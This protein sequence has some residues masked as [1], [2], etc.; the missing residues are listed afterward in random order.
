MAE[1]LVFIV[2]QKIGAALGREALNVV[3]T[4]LQKQPP[5]L[6]DVENNMRQLKIE[7]NVM[8]AFLTQQQI[9]FSQDRA[10]DAWLDEVKNVA[11][12][13]EDVID[14]YVY[15]AGQTA[16]E[17]S[18]LKKLFH[19]SKTTSDWHII[20]T[21]LSQIKSRLQNLTNMKARYGISA[22]DSEDGST[23]SHESLKELTSD[24]A[25]FDTEDDMVG[26]KE[27]YEKV[28]K[29]LI[30][31][32]E[33]R[34]VISI[35]G[36]GGL[37]KTTLARAIYKKNEIRKNFDCFSWIT[38]SQN[39]KVEDLFRRILKQLLDMNENIPDQT[40]IMYRVSLVERLRNYLQDKKYLIFLD[41]M[42]S[43]DA[44][45]LLD[46]AFV[47]NKK[48]SR[49]VITTR[50]EDVASI[51]NNG[52]SFKPKYLPRGDA[53]DLFCRKAFHRLDQNGCPQVVMHWAE[54]IVSKCEGLPLAI[55]AIGSLLSYKQIDEAEWKLFY[56]QLNWQLTKNQKLN[57]VTSIL[58]L[59][60]DYLPANLKNCF[61]YC[62]M[63][64][65]DHEIRRKQIIRLWIAEG[66]I[67]ERGDITLEEVA[68]DYL[69]ELVQRSLLQVAWTKEY[70]RPK[71]F[72]MHDLVRDITVT[73]CKTEKFSLL[74]D[75]T[76]VTKLSDEARRVS[77][78]KGGKAMESGQG[79]RKIRSFIL[80]DEEVQFSW[81]QKATSN[82]RL[83]RVLSLRY[84][85]IVKLPDAV[86][87]LFNLHYL[88]LRHSEVQE[89][90]QSIGKLRK[91]Q[92][93][94]LRETFVEQLPE[95]IKFLTKL[96]FLS[97]DIDCDPSNL[98]RHFPRFQ[99]TR[100]CSEFYLL[101]DL[102]VLGDIKAS[103]HVVT[104]LNRLTQLRCLGIRDVKQDHMEK[105]CVSIKSMPNLI[106]LGIVSCG[107]DEILDLQHLD[108][109]PDLEW[110]HLRGKLH[111][112]GA[113]SKLQN[114]SKLRYLSIGWSRLQV[115]PLPAISHLSN[116]AELY[117]QEAYD[118]LLMTFQAG[119]FPNLRELGL[120]DMDQ[121]RSID[122][123]A[124]TMS[125]LSILV[126]CGLQNM[127]S[128]PV[129]FKYL[130]S[131]QILR[132]WDMPK[133]FMERTHAEDHVYVKH[134]HQIRYH[135]LRVKRWK[136]TSKISHLH[137]IL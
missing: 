89:I 81:I 57:Y 104:N 41:D 113:T 32:E 11:H 120:A 16:K 4:Q 6:V 1:A 62:S 102:H 36:M 59:S 37:G 35:C 31:G 103:K 87:Y 39:Y 118:G 65:E 80:F 9:H 122:I 123:E 111:G 30:H 58:N 126:L 70:E 133:E 12:E 110:L 137:S 5:T 127:I 105:L 78:V 92:T 20:A 95:E 94:D 77:L 124:G 88:D 72:R 15:L 115:D 54:K 49:I 106:R 116:L 48:G 73:K 107:E 25:Y 86:T 29:L 66:F 129:G 76:C 45:I 82:F 63:F 18:K 130:T 53:W 2:L 23:S 131:L 8:K 21:Q 99:A 128:V 69:K 85:K 136:F 75:N 100:I 125:N 56:G 34:S 22:N 13:A 24:S 61:L 98:H 119:W 51:A 83:L 27:E 3:G 101:K 7:F 33:T 17:T 19:C 91:L 40:D 26:N 96:R 14:E 10:Y 44:W 42:W 60:F 52:C 117:L 38:I 74:A 97:V 121:L 28:M 135:A 68:E 71:S 109:V 46:R 43:Q 90:Q 93:L 67:E 50:N 134:I 108:H 55:V 132:L 79:A 47:K 64:P 112:A 84:A 114:F